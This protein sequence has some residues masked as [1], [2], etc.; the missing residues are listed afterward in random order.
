MGK[1]NNRRRKRQ[2]SSTRG[3]IEGETSPSSNLSADGSSAMWKPVN[4][5]LGRSTPETRGPNNDV[6]FDYDLHND[7]VGGGEKD[8]MMDE[9]MFNKN[10]HYDNP[11]L[12]KI[13]DRDLHMQPGEDC[14][15]FFG[16]E[17]LDASAYQV[18]GSGSS[19]RL[20]IVND[21]NRSD[22]R[23][24]QDKEHKKQTQPEKKLKDESSETLRPTKK[25]KKEKKPMKNKPSSDYDGGQEE[26]SAS[27]NHDS[28]PK[29][30]SEEDI[31]AT[32]LS[33]SKITGGAMLHR[34]LAESLCR[35]GFHTPTPIQAATLSA[36][37]M[38]R[39]N[40]VGAAPTGS[41][42]TLAFLLPIL[43]KLL[44]DHEEG[45]RDDDDEEFRQ[46]QSQTRRNK[47]NNKSIKAL[48]M[49]PTRELAQQIHKEC[50]KLVPDQCVT[51]V[52][53]IALVKQARLLQT[54]RPSVIVGT[55]GRVFQMVRSYRWQ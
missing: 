34:R 44:N 36:S 30:I 21:N 22:S 31:Q 49:T 4:V 37:I 27:Q 15:M 9:E 35:L 18:V 7:Q 33:W 28:H 39:R 20:L 3:D 40:M 47:T 14:A 24:A 54:K 46:K 53:G 1:G 38:G 41:G 8:M 6:D 11:K 17:V 43:D 42:K 23:A 29:A 32:A 45:E 55:P 13:A 50:D 2:P 19:K 48:I 52:G 26:N 51:L 25:Q 16:L 12:S 10:N 5:H